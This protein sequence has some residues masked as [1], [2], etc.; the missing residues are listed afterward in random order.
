MPTAMPSQTLDAAHYDAT[1][2]NA[3]RP[4]LLTVLSVKCAV[5]AL[6]LFSV[7]MAPPLSE[8]SRY[9]TTDAQVAAVN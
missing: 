4:V 2:V 6:L 9:L 1:P 7:S 8:E 3:L 5:A